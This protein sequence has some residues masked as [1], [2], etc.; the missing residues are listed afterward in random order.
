MKRIIGCGNLLLQ[1][2]GVGIHLIEYLKHQTLPEDIELID[3]ATGG[4]DLI[5]FIE[6]AEKVVIVD[7]IRAGSVPGAIYRFTPDNFETNAELNT[8]LHDVTLKDIFRIIQLKRILP[9]VVIFGV[10]PKAMDLGMELTADIRRVVPEL[11]ALVLE[12]INH[13]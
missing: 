2:E 1:D 8:S 3:G 5:P 7:A 6:D 10:E 13:A 4:F 11:S 12:E 9:P